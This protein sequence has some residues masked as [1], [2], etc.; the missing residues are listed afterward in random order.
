MN[1]LLTCNLLKGLIINDCC[2]RQ[3]SFWHN[4]SH[5]SF[6]CELYYCANLGRRQIN[7]F[8]IPRLRF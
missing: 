4:N 2:Y 7:K 3:P 8:F 1:F 5:F 6:P